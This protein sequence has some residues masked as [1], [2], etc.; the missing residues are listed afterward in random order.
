MPDHE[1]KQLCARFDNTSENAWLEDARRGLPRKDDGGNETD[2]L[3][4]TEISAAPHEALTVSNM[5][6]FNK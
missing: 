2:A 5:P 1:W 4:S 6:N 3:R